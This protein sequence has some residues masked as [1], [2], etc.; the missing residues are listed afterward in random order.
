MTKNPIFYTNTYK[1]IEAKVKYLLNDHEDFLSTRI[2]RNVREVGDTVETIIKENFHKILG[3]LN[4][5]YFV[6]PPRFMANFAFKTADDY[7][8]VIDIITYRTDTKFD[9]PN[10]I[11][12]ERLSRFYEVDRNYFVLLL[13][14]YSVED[15]S[16]KA[17]HVQFVPIE[18]LGWDCL[19]IDNIGWGEIQI[20]N[21]KRIMVNPQ[22]SRKEWMIELC[23]TLTKFYPREIAKI[24][25]Y[26]KHFEKT[27]EFW[28]GKSNE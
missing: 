19:A 23:N 18:F 3:D 13:I 26:I 21:A 8:H 5:E 4:I 9:L 2:P 10:L 14:R 25:D 28:L 11:S 20:A 22:Y 6:K 7:Y 16:N 1:K 15:I 27:R 17:T 12:V 24:N